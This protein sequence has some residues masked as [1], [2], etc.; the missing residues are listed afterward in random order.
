MY[1][2]HFNVIGLINNPVKTQIINELEE[3]D[4]I[5]QV[6]VDLVRSV[7]AV[8]YNEPANKGDIRSCIERVGCRIK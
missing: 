2:V 6:D 5:H 7:V 1:K 3:L 4:G 8:E